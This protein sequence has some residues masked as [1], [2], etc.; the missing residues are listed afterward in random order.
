MAEISAFYY[1]FPVGPHFPGKVK[2]SIFDLKHCLHQGLNKT[3]LLT[4][5]QNFWISHLRDMSMLA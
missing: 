3:S 4:K 2:V 5:F 1:D